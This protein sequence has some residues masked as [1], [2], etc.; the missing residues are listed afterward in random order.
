MRSTAATPS[1]VSINVVTGRTV[2]L[3]HA[4]LDT[5][6]WRYVPGRDEL[7]YLRDRAGERPTLTARS[8]ATGETRVLLS[9]ENPNQE[10]A[11]FQVG[12]KGAE[13]AYLLQGATAGCMS[14]PCQLRVVSIA[15]TN[16]RVV[17]TART[18]GQSWGGI[19]AFSPDGRFLTSLGQI[20]RTDTGERQPLVAPGQLPGGAAM[21]PVEGGSFMPD[22]SAVFVSIRT[23]R[24]EIRRWEG[25][26]ADAV[27]RLLKR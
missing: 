3:P 22:G 23:V 25:F 14:V 18:R 12:T 16:D 7:L 10:I 9:I 15:G 6:D 27:A 20:V 26:S 21:V 13:V 17:A 8:L 19:Q 4:V 2:P 1:L 5:R 11:D 24:H